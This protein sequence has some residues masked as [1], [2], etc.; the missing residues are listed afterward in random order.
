MLLITSTST[1]HV[2]LHIIQRTKEKKNMIY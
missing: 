1:Q 2:T